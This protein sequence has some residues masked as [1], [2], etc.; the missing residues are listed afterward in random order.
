[1][2]ACGV[3][4]RLHIAPTTEEN[5]YRSRIAMIK[6]RL[7]SLTVYTVLIALF[8]IGIIISLGPEQPEHEGK[9]LSEWIDDI[10]DGNNTEAAGIAIRNMG[11]NAIPFLINMLSSRDSKGKEFLRLVG[12]KQSFIKLSTMSATERYALA[13]RIFEILGDDVKAAA[14]PQLAHVLTNDTE[15]SAFTARVLVGLGVE[16]I[17][18]LA[19]ALTNQNS[20]VRTHAAL[21]LGSLRVPGQDPESPLINSGPLYWMNQKTAQGIVVP[22]LIHALKDKANGTRSAAAWSL[23]QIEYDASLVVPALCETL[24]DYDLEVRLSAAGSLGQFAEKAIAAVPIL[25]K[26]I[27]KENGPDRETLIYSL[28]QIDPTAMVSAN[29]TSD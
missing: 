28:K 2:V 23:G 29:Q 11:T 6:R 15:S 9:P 13:V 20:W 26:A 21:V 19:S 3:V 10:V 25:L 27:A 16:G 14:T 8:A 1:M 18:P 24:S 22:A 7:K 17:L 12:E 5:F 4:E